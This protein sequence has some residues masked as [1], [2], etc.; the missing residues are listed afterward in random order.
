LIYGLH[1]NRTVRMCCRVSNC[2]FVV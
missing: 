2:F 1:K